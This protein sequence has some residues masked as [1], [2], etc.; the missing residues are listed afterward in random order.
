MGLDPNVE[1][2]PPPE[3]ARSVPVPSRRWAVI[4]NVTVSY[5]SLALGLARNFGLVPLYFGYIGL[6]EFGAWI[7]TGNVLAYLSMMDFGLNGVLAQ[8]AAMAYGERNKDQLQR[9]VGT[10]LLVAALLSSMP[11]LLALALA[12]F[13]PGIVHI[14]DPAMAG[15]LSQCFQIAGLAGSFTLFGQATGNL[16]RSF[17]KPLLPGVFDVFSDAV[18]MVLTI[19][20]VV[21]GYGLY[22][23]AAGL[24]FCGVARAIMTAAICIWYCR[25]HLRLRF[26]CSWATARSLW[27]LSLYQVGAVVAGKLILATD[28]LMIG[29][30][31]GPA[32]AAIYYAT[33]RAHEI[34]RLLMGRFSSSLTPS[35]THLYGEGRVDRFKEIVFHALKIQVL[36]GAIGIAGTIAFNE[37]FVRLWVGGDKF[38]GMSINVLVGLWS[39]GGIVSGSISWETIFAMGKISTLTRT[40]WIEALIRVPLAV[41]LMFAFGLVGLP[42]AALAAQAVAIHWLLNLSL[43][44]AI[45]MGKAELRRAGAN[46]A[47]ACAG[48]LLPMVIGLCLTSWL[49][50]WKTLIAGAGAFVVAS[51]TFE[52]LMDRS[53]LH[54][55]RVPTNAQESQ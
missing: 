22:G 41:L 46:L 2:S 8:R 33:T 16:L 37:P 25:R 15:R 42:I 53:I 52:V 4:Q 20:L 1:G 32:A 36:L 43:V 40:A 49:K 44:R 19:V 10:G 9:I 21:K 55:F 28:S 31:L 5:L 48:P 7:A 39:L 18:G 12:P 14:H 54:P 13:L 34:V 3:E 17:Q 47:R 6:V 45:R 11:L 23:I 51:L 24:A 29:I 38:A 26:V 27:R 35:L 50:D 30:I